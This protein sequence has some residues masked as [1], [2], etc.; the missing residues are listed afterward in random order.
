[1][2][3]GFCFF[4]GIALGAI[5]GGLAVPVVAYLYLVTHIRH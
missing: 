3:A 1:M 5:A 2:S 4:A